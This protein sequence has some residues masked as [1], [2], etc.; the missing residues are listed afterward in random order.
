MYVVVMP[1]QAKAAAAPKRARLPD[2]DNRAVQALVSEE[3]ARREK[4]NARW[5]S[6][7]FGQ[8]PT[9]RDVVLAELKAAN[10]LHDDRYFLASM[11]QQR[12]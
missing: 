9:D 1:P 12:I 7:L 2:A 4:A 11:S 3:V 10:V 5:W 8:Q 6:R